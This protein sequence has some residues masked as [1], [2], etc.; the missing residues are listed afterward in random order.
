MM[1]LAFDLISTF[2]IGSTL[3]VATTERRIVPC[4]TA[5]ILAGS[6]V[7]E[8]PVR[9]VKPQMPATTSRTRAETI[10][11]LLDFFITT[12]T[13]TNQRSKGFHPAYV[14]SANRQ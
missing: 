1:P 11:A 10:R 6:M 4:S 2:V 9:A 13:S 5:M 7:V 12:S 8:A 14:D 3:P